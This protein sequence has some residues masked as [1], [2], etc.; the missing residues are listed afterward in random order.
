MWMLRGR[1]VARNI[2]TLFSGWLRDAAPN[3]Y[4]IACFSIF[5]LGDWILKVSIC[6]TDKPI[7]QHTS[8]H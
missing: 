8:I 5:K 1:N 6:G 4:Y 7:F 3:M 2:E